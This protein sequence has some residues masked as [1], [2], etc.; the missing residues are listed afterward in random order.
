LYSIN[1]VE[2]ECVKAGALRGTINWLK[3]ENA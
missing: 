3:M 1:V 2:T